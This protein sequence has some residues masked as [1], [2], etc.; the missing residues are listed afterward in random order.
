MRLGARGSAGA[1]S[2]ALVERAGGVGTDE[3]PPVAAR[4]QVQTQDAEVVVLASF[5]A[6]V[7]TSELPQP[8]AAGTDDEL[9][10]PAGGGATVGVEGSETLVVVVVAG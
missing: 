6:V 3:R 9:S 4:L 10:D 8:L 7:V 5:D 2:P 1:G